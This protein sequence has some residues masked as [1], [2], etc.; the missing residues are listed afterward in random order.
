[1][2]IRHKKMLENTPAYVTAKNQTEKH[3][4][5]IWLLSIFGVTLLNS[6]KKHLIG[7]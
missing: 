4:P 7:G 1:M 3:S 5:T 6:V 2:Y